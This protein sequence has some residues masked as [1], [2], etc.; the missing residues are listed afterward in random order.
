MYEWLDLPE[1]A[2]KSW[3]EF[4]HGHVIASEGEVAKLKSGMVDE[5]QIIKFV[6][7]QEKLYSFP[8]LTPVTGFDDIKFQFL[9]AVRFD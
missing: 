8:G 7:L 6:V 4:A 2:A 9:A 3:K 5:N 1:Y